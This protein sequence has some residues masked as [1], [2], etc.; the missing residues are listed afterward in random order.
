MS[1]RKI[2]GRLLDCTVCPD[3]VCRVGM[4]WRNVS[5]GRSSTIVGLRRRR[6]AAMA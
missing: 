2:V 3:D 6:C 5:N 1:K 4:Q